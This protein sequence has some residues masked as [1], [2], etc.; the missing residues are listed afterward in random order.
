MKRGCV[1]DLAS[2][3]E[4]DCKANSDTCKVCKGKN[5][6]AK[7]KFHECYNCNSDT[8]TQCA[9]A[10][11]S[12]ATQVCKSYQSDCIIGVDMR[13]FTHRRCSNQRINFGQEF[14]KK[15][16]SCDGDKCNN[17]VYPSD[18][19]QCYQCNDDDDKCNMKYQSSS[20]KPE[21]CRVFSVNDQC[22]TYMCPGEIFS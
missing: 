2:E 13:G 12:T 17:E 18:R 16:Q 6:N 8:D 19:L 20:F 4:I 21:P 5:C 22:F 7:V 10:N 3:E 15:F 11:S 1:N 9:S 14:Y